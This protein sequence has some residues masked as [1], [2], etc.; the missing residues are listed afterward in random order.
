MLQQH[1]QGSER[2]MV[3]MLNDK[4]NENRKFCKEITT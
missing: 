1:E 2:I 3:N 4:N